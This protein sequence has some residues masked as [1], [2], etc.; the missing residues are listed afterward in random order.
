MLDN[1][2][3]RL[4]TSPAMVLGG[5]KNEGV[6]ML[7]AAALADYGA[8]RL[9]LHAI[10]RPDGSD[11]G[12]R[13]LGQWLP[14]AGAAIAAVLLRQPEMASSII[15]GASIA[16]LSLVAGLVLLT[17]GMDLLPSTRR[18]W[19]FLLPA[20]L[21]PLM[22]GFS[23]HLGV[24]HAIGML[25]LGVAVLAVWL[26]KEQE[27]PIASMAQQSTSQ[28]GTS[29]VG[30]QGSAV[31]HYSLGTLAAVGGAG[32]WIV[33]IGILLA[34]GGGFFSVLGCRSAAVGSPFLTPPL[35]ATVILSPLLVLPTIGT[36]T[37]VA[38]H[39]HVGRALSALVGTVLLNLCLLLPI[40][41][42]LHS[43]MHANWSAIDS[44]PGKNVA[45]KI[46]LLE[47][48]PFPYP[49]AAWRIDTVL[50]VVLG[51]AA[52]PIATGR[53]LLGRG[54]ALLLILGFMVYLGAQA[55]VIMH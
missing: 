25:I 35:I 13:A 39:G 10:A 52:V 8:A 2:A 29:S 26:Q 16:C 41:V 27:P 42:L 44:M 51:F 55:F 9:A 32:V 46:L 1:G 7:V 40:V 49:V 23:G 48:P 5:G 21:V 12:R 19:P 18:A 30:T 54:E 3:L 34:A 45:V 4:H 43:F 37:A 20:A 33:A 24:W 22:A 17:S 15:L 28:S 38:H 36:S 53:W 14:I 47:F 31:L 6:L 50:L 11:A